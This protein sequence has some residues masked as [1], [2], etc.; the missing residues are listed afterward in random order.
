MFANP[1]P[2]A[3]TNITG[4]EKMQATFGIEPRDK[5]GSPK[6]YSLFS[7]KNKLDHEQKRTE[8]EGEEEHSPRFAD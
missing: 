4:T 7:V 1:D 8:S 2:K 6:R 3:V 5:D